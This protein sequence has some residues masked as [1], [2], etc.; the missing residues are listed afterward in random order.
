MKETIFIPFFDGNIKYLVLEN[1]VREELIP[2]IIH[3]KHPTNPNLIYK[4][5]IKSFNE[6][7]LYSNCSKFCGYK[8]KIFK[9]N[10]NFYKN[11]NESNLQHTCQPVNLES[12]CKLSKLQK[13]FIIQISNN[14]APSSKNLATFK[15]TWDKLNEKQNM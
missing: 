5:S 12:N 2:F 3:T 14:K 6:K 11:K 10:G 15:E 8:E 1:I 13:E 9:I 4:M 7:K